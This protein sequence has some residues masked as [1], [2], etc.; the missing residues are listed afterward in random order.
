MWISLVPINLL[1]ICEQ[2][3]LTSLHPGNE[4]KANFKEDL[5]L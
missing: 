3:H 2:W 4:L 5:L 1:Q